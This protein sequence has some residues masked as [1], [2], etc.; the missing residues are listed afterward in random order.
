MYNTNR[1]NETIYK[2]LPEDGAELGNQR[3]SGS[4]KSDPNESGYQSDSLF[5][6]FEKKPNSV[7]PV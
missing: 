3:P 1:N 4:A 7:S 2:S 6:T 5:S